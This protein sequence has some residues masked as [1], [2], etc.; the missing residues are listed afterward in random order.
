MRCFA[1][2]VTLSR[3]ALPPFPAYTREAEGEVAAVLL[4]LLLC[5]EDAGRT[6][7]R[8]IDKH[9][10]NCS[11]FNTG[12]RNL[13]RFGLFENRELKRMFAP[14]RGGKLFTVEL[15]SLYS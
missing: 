1:S 14:I 5:S 12:D 11:S 9:L 8:N 13:Q 10:P 2:S 3:K 6:L 4:A 15:H 7:L